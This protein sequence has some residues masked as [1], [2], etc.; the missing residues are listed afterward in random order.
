MSCLSGVFFEK[1]IKR[2]G[3][4]MKRLILILIACFILVVPQFAIADR[5]QEPIPPSKA[6]SSHSDLNHL[7]AIAKEITSICPTTKMAESCFDC[8]V[9]PDFSLIEKE[10]N[11]NSLFPYG[12]DMTVDPNGKTATVLITGIES[13]E[14]DA[15]FEYLNWHPEIKHAIFEV[16][17]PGGSLMEAWRIVGMMEYHKS[18][19]MVIET[20]VHGFAASAGFIIFANGSKGHR[21]AS[22]QA[23]L[24]WHELGSFKLFS[25]DTP[26]TIEDEAVV[27]R[28]LQNTLSAYLAERSNLTKEQWDKK[29]HKK[30]F[31][32][33]GKQARKYGLS[34]GL[35]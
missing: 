10:A 29:V 4:T 8:H 25:F 3:R 30:D 9:K 7:E 35:P 21:F 22:Y 19:G 15:F 32:I 12:P 16:M 14:I 27:L 1:I 20:R 13:K 23:E 34:D 31:W 17:S 5:E 24:M 28:H 33:S 6:L 26:S 18:R 2:K 11:G